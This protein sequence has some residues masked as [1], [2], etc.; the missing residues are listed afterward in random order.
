MEDDSSSTIG[1]LHNH[2]NVAPVRALGLSPLKPQRRCTNEFL[3][4]LIRFNAYH[5][6]MIIESVSLCGIIF[7][8]LLIFYFPLLLLFFCVHATKKENATFHLAK[9]AHKKSY[10]GVLRNL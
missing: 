8:Q 2:G 9:A 5:V 10:Y 4:L 3:H 7:M 6:T 1:Y